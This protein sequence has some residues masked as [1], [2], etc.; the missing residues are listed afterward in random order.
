MLAFLCPSAYC[1]HL[2]AHTTAQWAVTWSDVNFS[3]AGNF[4][5]KCPIS[6]FPMQS[7]EMETVCEGRVASYNAMVTRRV[8]SEAGMARYYAI[9]LSCWPINHQTI[10]L[11]YSTVDTAHITDV[12][13]TG[14]SPY[15]WLMRAQSGC[16]PGTGFARATD[17]VQGLLGL[18]SSLD[19]EFGPVK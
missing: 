7:S 12:W 14:C 18:L 8:C 15:Q 2:R 1:A 19:R 17:Q 10:S 4:Q 6:L 11:N 5:T 3:S 16:W 9:M 13:Y